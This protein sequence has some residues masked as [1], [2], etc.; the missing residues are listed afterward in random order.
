MQ[1][2]QLCLLSIRLDEV[3]PASQ[4]QIAEEVPSHDLWQSPKKH[5]MRGNATKGVS[6][7]PTQS[8]H[9]KASRTVLLSQE[10]LKRLK[11][12]FPKDDISR[13]KDQEAMGEANWANKTRTTQSGTFFVYLPKLL[14]WHQSGAF[15]VTFKKKSINSWLDKLKEGMIFVLSAIN[16]DT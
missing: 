12:S 13:T 6:R 3:T 9:K 11:K 7:D 14:H 15:L 1:I 4:G 16:T 8:I 5:E 2:P 10:V